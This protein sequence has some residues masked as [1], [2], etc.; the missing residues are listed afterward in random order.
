MEVLN[1]EKK[2][3]DKRSK[4]RRKQNRRKAKSKSVEPVA[5]EDTYNEISVA[6]KSNKRST[7]S[8]AKNQDGTDVVKKKSRNK[9][10]RR[11]QSTDHPAAP[12][13]AD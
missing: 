3:D 7:P 4:D 8:M 13:K 11:K 12:S 6:D 1:A 2:P 9:R 5:K 10:R